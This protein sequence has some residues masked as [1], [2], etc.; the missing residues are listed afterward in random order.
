MKSIVFFCRN[1]NATIKLLNKSL[2]NDVGNL[3]AKK[4]NI[5]A[6]S[7]GLEFITYSIDVQAIV[8]IITDMMKTKYSKPYINAKSALSDYF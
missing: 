3:L 2:A 6:N 5:G 1:N 4:K 7:A 8:N